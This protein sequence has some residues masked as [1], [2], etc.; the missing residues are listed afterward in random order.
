MMG[1]KLLNQEKSEILLLGPPKL[2]NSLSGTLKN[3][4]S[5]VKTTFKNSKSILLLEAI[6]APDLKRAIYAVICYWLYFN[7]S[8]SVASATC[9]KYCSKIP[10]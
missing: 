7:L 3:L 9:T 2:T 4:S 6:L 10:K 8:K 5:L 1:I